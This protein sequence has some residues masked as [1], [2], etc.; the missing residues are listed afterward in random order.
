MIEKNKNLIIKYK[1]LIIYVAVG[2]LT[3]A[4]NFVTFI[5]FNSIL[6]NERYLVTNIIAWFAAITFS[7]IS[8]K[9]LVFQSKS[10]EV[11]NIIKELIFF[12]GARVATLGVEEAGLYFFVDILSFNKI[13]LKIFFFEISGELIAKAFVGVVVVI[14]NYLFSKFVIFK[15]KK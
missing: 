12:F 1:E 13:S 11:K 7:Y 15:K 9:K 10:R 2:V 4:V 5:A 6:G 3:A 14:I 8:T